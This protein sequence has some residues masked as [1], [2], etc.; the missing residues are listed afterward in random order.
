MMPNTAVGMY[1]FDVAGTE[2]YAQASGATLP[3]ETDQV[4]GILSA[5]G[6]FRAEAVGSRAGEVIA[7]AKYDGYD[8]LGIR[9]E[10]CLMAAV[11]PEPIEE[12]L[13]RELHH[14]LISLERRWSRGLAMP[15]KADNMKDARAGF[16]SRLFRRSVSATSRVHTAA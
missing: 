3:I 10:R 13:L 4:E 12:P 9:G 11:S 6:G 2:P 14:A 7:R 15:G 8:I 5:I 16:L 1:L